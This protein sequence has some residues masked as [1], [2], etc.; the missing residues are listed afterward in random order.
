MYSRS[1]H[2]ILAV[3]AAAILV[4]LGDWLLALNWTSAEVNSWIQLGSLTS[5]SHLLCGPR[6]MKCT[7]KPG[8]G[9]LMFM[10][11]GRK[12]KVPERKCWDGQNGWRLLKDWTSKRCLL[13]SFSVKVQKHHGHMSNLSQGTDET[14]SPHVTEVHKLNITQ[15][16]VQFFTQIDILSTCCKKVFEPLLNLMLLIPWR[17]ESRFVPCVPQKF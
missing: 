10:N 7:E 4:T 8:S 15:I 3:L 13:G 16:Q 1:R 5:A 11:E 17:F 6:Q 9:Q 2:E 12:T 14:S